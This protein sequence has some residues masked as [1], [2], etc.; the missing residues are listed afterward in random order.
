MKIGTFAIAIHG[1]AG[2]LS[3]ENMTEELERAHRD[4]LTQSLRSGHAILEAG[5]SALSAVEAAI[6]VLEDSP[7]FN[8]GKGSVFTHEERIEMDAA[9]M[10]GGLRAA[11]AV[12]AVTTIKNPIKAARAVMEKSS[13]VLLA[14]SGAEAFAELVGCEIVS[15][16]YF[17]TEFRREQLRRAKSQE[18]TVLDHDGGGMASVGSSSIDSSSGSNQDKKFGTVGAVALDKNG[19]IAAGTSTGGMTNK[20]FHRIGDTPLIGAGTFAD[21]ETCAVSCT[22]HGEFFIRNVVA[23]DV[24]ALMKYKGLTLTQAA[25]HV[26]NEK[27]RSIGGMGGLIAIDRSGTIV[28]PFN[29]AG[30]YRG[31]IGVDGTERVAIFS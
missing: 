5:G 4:V 17:E 10:H 13:H 15:P 26:V 12:A 9:V 7:L 18:R 11:G 24:T 6:V 21:N 28:M 23:Y 2:T 1:G 30:M 22:G 3:R 27:L 20:R 8:A 14:E 16:E 29:T 31:A 25:D 19:D